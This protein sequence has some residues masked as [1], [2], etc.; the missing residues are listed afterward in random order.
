V[1]GVLEARLKADE[2]KRGGSRVDRV[3]VQ[4]AVALLERRYLQEIAEF[5]ALV[6]DVLRR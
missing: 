6:E 1:K 3:A 2:P 4:S 5:R